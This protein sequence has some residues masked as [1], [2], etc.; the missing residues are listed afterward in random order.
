MPSEKGTCVL[1]KFNNISEIS[2]F[3]RRLVTSLCTLAVTDIQFGLHWLDLWLINRNR[4]KKCSAHCI[5]IPN[6]LNCSDDLSKIRKSKKLPI[7]WRDARVCLLPF[8]CRKQRRIYVKLF[9]Y[10]YGKKDCEA[11]SLKLT[12]GEHEN[13]MK[14]L[15]DSYVERVTIQHLKTWT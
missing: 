10:K 3:W 1:G 15:I 8:L 4:C 7:K 2:S 12:H 11:K 13:Q 5:C 9:V 6:T 14:A